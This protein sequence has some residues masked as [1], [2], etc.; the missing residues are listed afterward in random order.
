MILQS[1]LTWILISLIIFYPLISIFQGLDITDTGYSVANYALFF[2][3]YEAIQSSSALWLTML[4]GASAESLFGSHFGLITHKVTDLF[5]VYINFFI[6]YKLLNKYFHTNVILIGLLISAFTLTPTLHIFSYQSATFT[7]YLIAVYFLY[8]GLTDNKPYFIFIAS[9]FL[10]LNFFIRMPNIL[11]IGFYIFLLINH[12]LRKDTL[13]SHSLLLQSSLYFLGYASAFATVL[14]SMAAL[15]HLHY[16][17]NNMQLIYHLLFYATSDNSHSG[18]SL[19]LLLFKDIQTIIF[20]SIKL[21]FIIVTALL[22]LHMSQKKG[23]VQWQYGVNTLILL[24][25]LPILLHAEGKI[26]YYLYAI[27]MAVLSYGL[28][29]YYKQRVYDLFL[30]TLLAFPLVFLGTLGSDS[31]LLFAIYHLPLSLTLAIVYVST[32]KFPSSLTLLKHPFPLYE[33]HINFVKNSFISLFSIGLI[34][35]GFTHTYNDQSKSQLLFSFHH[36]KLV[37][38]YTSKERVNVF[39]DA[40]DHLQKY[41]KKD[42]ILLSCDSTPIIYYATQTIPMIDTTWIETLPPK[43]IKAKLQS[44]EHSTVMR[45]I[46]FRAK[47]DNFGIAWPQEKVLLP[48]ES[49]S[50]KRDI[51]DD[52]I[53][54]NHYQKVWENEFFEIYRV[55][56]QI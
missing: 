29:D 5:L 41:V 36:P 2:D 12:Y 13:N 42:D 4:I 25:L 48:I 11:G 43:T 27:T 35:F 39:E 20:L 17:I 31:G 32:K 49:V 23:N 14:S 52:Y 33:N 47:Y 56:I 24:V 10:G 51:L 50:M 6:I 7:F 34:Y 28:Y 44:Y 18:H 26:V 38:V 46:V 21:I 55:E 19:F 45:P 9:F 3:H 37:G 54:R 53:R 8:F 22:L 40:L 16:F 30:L 1:R 15:G